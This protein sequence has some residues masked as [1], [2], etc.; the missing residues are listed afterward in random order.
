M[1][2]VVWLS[3]RCVVLGIGQTEHR[4]GRFAQRQV[5]RR[6]RLIGHCLSLVACTYVQ[7]FGYLLGQL[8]Y[9][10]RQNLLLT[11]DKLR[12]QLRT[13]GQ[14]LV[15]YQVE[16]IA[17]GIHS[18]SNRHQ[19][20]YVVLI[21]RVGQCTDG[22]HRHHLDVLYHTDIQ[23]GIG[24]NHRRIVARGNLVLRRHRVR[25]GLIAR[26]VEYELRCGSVTVLSG[27]DV[28]RGGTST[29]RSCHGTNIRVGLV[30]RCSGKLHTS[31]RLQIHLVRVVE[32]RTL[33][34]GCRTVCS[35]R[36]A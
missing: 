24:A 10:L 21:H 22:R 27:E 15:A 25:V 3:Y 36:V 1:C 20:S 19:R 34:Q 2:T 5:N 14:R 35:R 6:L 32:R 30:A 13:V 7:Q 29:S 28:A 8:R 9:C 11:Q 33:R 31:R 12:L 26:Q 16:L 4:I 18:L 23:V 17:L